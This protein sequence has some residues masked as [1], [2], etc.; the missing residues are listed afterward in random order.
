M[1]TPTPAHIQH[2]K[3]AY[4]TFESSLL[5]KGMLLARDT[6]IGY[7]GVTHIPALVALF[8]QLKPDKQRLLD[9]GSGDGR[10]VL[11]ASLFGMHATGI[12]ADDLLMNTALDMK[13]KIALPHFSTAQFHQ[14]DFMKHD[15]SVYDFLYVSPDKPFHRGLD[16]KLAKELSG[17]LIVHSFEFLPTSLSLENEFFFHGEKFGIYKKR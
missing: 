6:G 8:S 4:D 11:L 7:W 2:I 17:K 1:P 14:D 15:I 10:V 12:E 3:Q 5:Q 9:L 13:R 16:K